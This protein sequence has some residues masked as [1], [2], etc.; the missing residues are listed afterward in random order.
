MTKKR[1]D[2]SSEWKHE[3]TKLRETYFFPNG[4][5]QLVDSFRDGK[6]IHWIAYDTLGAVTGGWTDPIVSAEPLIKKRHWL[7]VMCF[8]IISLI[9]FAIWKFINYRT[10]YYTSF[11]L[12]WLV[13]FTSFLEERIR[14]IS[15]EVQFTI[16]TC[17]GWSILILLSL[18]FLFS[19]GN[20]LFKVS[21]SKINSIAIMIIAGILALILYMGYM[22]ALAG[23]GA[24]G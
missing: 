22:S 5:I 6:S 4:K 21:I 10:V 15:E 7:F 20:L 18:T 16:H 9:V 1:I 23:R 8:L 2:F 14:N 3:D 12:S 11:T 17:Q 24:V 13:F 19:L